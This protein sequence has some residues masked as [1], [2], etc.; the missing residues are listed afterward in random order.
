MEDL[1]VAWRRW[2]RGPG[3]ASPVSD[4]A[5]AGVLAILLLYGSYGEGNP[6]NL[7][8]LDQFRGQPVPHPTAALA[9]VAVACLAL[10]WRRRYPVMVLAVS[11]AAA[12]VEG[13]RSAVTRSAVR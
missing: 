7:S 4:A 13:T 1:A 5:R 9:L 2:L 11:A 8:D 10:A 12:P 3:W 6:K